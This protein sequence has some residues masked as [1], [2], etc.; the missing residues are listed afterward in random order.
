MADQFLDDLSAVV[1][2]RI[3]ADPFFSD[4]TIKE[5]RKGNIQKDVDAALARVGMLTKAGKLGACVVVRAAMP[6]RTESESSSLLQVSLEIEVCENPLINSGSNGT[7][8]TAARI[9]AYLFRLLSDYHDQNLNQTLTAE[10][11]PA[12]TQSVDDALL[13]VLRLRCFYPLEYIEKCSIGSDGA[14]GTL[15]VE[16]VSGTTFRARAT[17]STSGALIHFAVSALTVSPVLP[18]SASASASSGAWYQFTVSVPSRIIAVAYA[19]NKLAS[20]SLWNE[21]G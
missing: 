7:G 12:V 2:Q 6:E 18:T 13:Y 15:K 17:T 10:E 11:R 4:I 20:D 1:A 14:G 8:K 16:L 9:W 21:V 19:S 5:E 3:A